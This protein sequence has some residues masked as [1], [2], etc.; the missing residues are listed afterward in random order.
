MLPVPLHAAIVHF[1]IVFAVVL[2]VAALISLLAIR[3]GGS[4]VR[5]WGATLVLMAALSA[6]SFAAVRSGEG[7]EERVE[8]IVRE[9]PLE[10]HEEAG[11]RFLVL[12]GFLVL[13]GATGLLPG[14]AGGALRLLGGAAT[15][16]VLAA[17]WQVGHSGGELVYRHGAAA[18]YS[19]PVQLMAAPTRQDRR[20]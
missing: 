1:P 11:E 9:Q 2:P 14:R 18:A 13:V 10:A 20:D 3:R 6:A 7:E 4:V 5:W 12:T 16:G 15:L 19:V 8:R 17:G